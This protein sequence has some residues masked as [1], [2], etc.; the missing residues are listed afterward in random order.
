MSEVRD[1]LRTF[2]IQPAQ[3]GAVRERKAVLGTESSEELTQY[4]AQIARDQ[5]GVA[6]CRRC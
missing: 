3:H 4:D 6:R 1:A 2:S 5:R